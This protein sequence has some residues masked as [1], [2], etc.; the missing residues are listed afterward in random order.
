MNTSAGRRVEVAHRIIAEP[1]I[2]QVVANAAIIASHDV[3]AVTTIDLVIARTTKQP[4]ISSESVQRVIA[5]ATLEVV[6][7]CRTGECVGEPGADDIFN[8]DDR[9]FA[10]TQG[11]LCTREAEVDA[12][13]PRS[14]RVAVVDS[15]NAI[16]TI[17]IVIGRGTAIGAQNVIARATIKFVRTSTTIKDVISAHAMERIAA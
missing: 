16:T 9:I 17:D 4:V 3:V 12:H 6:I 2:K 8:I 1:A 5:S 14:R 15:I 7:E 11:I 10:S 13:T